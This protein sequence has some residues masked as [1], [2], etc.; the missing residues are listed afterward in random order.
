MHFA[1][2]CH[3][4]FPPRYCRCRCTA[5]GLKPLILF[6]DE[7]KEMDILFEAQLKK[8]KRYPIQRKE[9]QKLHCIYGK[10]GSTVLHV[11]SLLASNSTYFPFSR[12]FT[13]YNVNGHNLGRY[14]IAP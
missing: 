12:V 11:F 13:H 8:K 3:V 5:K 9:K 2:T 1:W 6:K 4:I 7:V 14:R 10:N